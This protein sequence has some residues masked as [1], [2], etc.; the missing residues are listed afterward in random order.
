MNMGGSLRLGIEL[1]YTF[2][3]ILK[4]EE[5]RPCLPLSG[6]ISN[7]ATGVHDQDWDV[8]TSCHHHSSRQ[9]K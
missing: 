1:F 6:L 3:E 5:Q 9:C 8:Y 2:W 4:K 7:S